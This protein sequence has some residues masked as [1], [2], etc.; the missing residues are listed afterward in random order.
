MV[1]ADSG[2]VACVVEAQP[3]NCNDSF[4]SLD[5]FIAVLVFA[6]FTINY[7]SIYDAMHLH[8]KLALLM[9]REKIGLK[10]AR[11]CLALPVMSCSELLW[12]F[13]LIYIFYI[14]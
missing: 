3:F 14:F 8:I 4:L 12:Y 1:V 5:C 7:L 6:F 10:I 9:Q 2:V 11:L 13:L